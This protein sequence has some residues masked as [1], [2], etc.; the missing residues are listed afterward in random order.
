MKRLTRKSDRRRSE[1]E[2]THRSA[3]E[4]RRVSLRVSLELGARQRAQRD[5]EVAN[6]WLALEDQV[7]SKG[8][9]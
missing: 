8:T 5:L 4:T 3:A 9:A 1:S 7:P 2:A 6:D